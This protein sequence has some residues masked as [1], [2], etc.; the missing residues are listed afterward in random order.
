MLCYV[1]NETA[2]I[3]AKLGADLFNIS[4]VTSHKTK[5]PRFLSHPVCVLEKSYQ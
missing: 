1:K 5:W 4:I 3:C 2:L